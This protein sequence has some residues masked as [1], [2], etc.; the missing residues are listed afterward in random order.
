MINFIH[1]IRKKKIYAHLITIA[2]ATKPELRTTDL[3]FGV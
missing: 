2:T 3:R 1:Q